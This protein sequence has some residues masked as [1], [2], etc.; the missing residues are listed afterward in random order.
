VAF[1]L[2]MALLAGLT[3][4]MAPALHVPATAVHETLKA[5][6][7]G[8]TEGKQH[9]WI[10]ATL[11]VAE[12][13]FA[14]VLLVGA[15]LLMRSFLQV[16]DVNLGFRPERTAAL[17]VDTD[18]RFT[19]KAEQNAYYDDVLRR[20]RDL[21]GI[22]AAG[23]TD[24]LPLGRNRAWGAAAKGQ[25][26]APGQYPNAY[27]RIV[28]DGY[29]KA[30]GIPIRA[31]RDLSP[32]DTP[33][34][35]PVIVINETMARR[36]WPGE[37]ALGK[38]V[39][40]GRNPR[41]VV[42][43]VADVRH[44]ALEE[45]SGLEMYIPLRQTGDFS[46]VDLVVR[47]ALPPAALASG[48][49]A[50]LQ[51]LDPTLP[52]NE[53]RTLQ[54]MVDK[55]VSPRRFVVLLLGGFAGF[56]LLLASLGI[57]GVISYSVHQRTQEIGIRMALGASATDVQVRI[58]VQTLGLAAIGIAIGTT[59]SWALARLLRG[60]LFGVTATDPLT[61]AGMVLILA[62]V[63]VAAGYLPGRRASRIDPMTALRAN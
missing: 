47:T 29:M 19:S 10:R 51:P 8:S 28:S 16:L 57:Y 18:R 59:A 15:G 58:V 56:A 9:H 33:A 20:M 54:Q 30:M 21:P 63:A 3:F 41:R 43:V 12:I 5:T 50:A 53:F 49:R 27:V 48:V 1:A 11:V 40:S 45:G 61:F 37:D 13:A 4:G 52:A 36:L 23:L 31:G 42:G 26:Y 46:S 2:G 60:F 6:G 39:V 34:S 62:G 7:R 22:E 14:C 38:F 35:D 25:V 55:A 24:A 17:R 44:L 32:Q